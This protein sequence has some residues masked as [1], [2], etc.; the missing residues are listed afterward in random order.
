MRLSE[1]E[2]ARRERYHR[3]ITGHTLGLFGTEQLG[4]Q[5]RKTAGPDNDT[6][7]IKDQLRSCGETLKM[8]NLSGYF[9]GKATKEIV[10]I[11]T[12]RRAL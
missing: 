6:L 3:E 7:N 5:L 12:A 9:T 11:K 10:I 1:C 8:L 2:R 4:H